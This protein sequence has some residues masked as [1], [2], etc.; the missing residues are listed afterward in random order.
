MGREVGPGVHQNPMS[1]ITMLYQGKKGWIQLPLAPRG[2][3]LERS[4]ALRAGALKNVISSP[5]NL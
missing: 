1:S 2:S 5:V 3:Q 4:S